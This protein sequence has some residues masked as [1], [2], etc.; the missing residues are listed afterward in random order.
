MTNQRSSAAYTLSNRHRHLGESST[1]V[2]RGG[3]L[4]PTPKHATIFKT[5]SSETFRRGINALI[6]RLLVPWSRN[7]G[8]LVRVSMRLSRT[9][10]ARPRILACCESP[11][12]AAT[13][14]ALGTALRAEAAGGCKLVRVSSRGERGFTGLDALGEVEGVVFEDY[15]G[16][17]VVSH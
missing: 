14:S 1:C 10:L 12:T 15:V 11:L 6:R 13:M 17:C 9:S 3:L 16:V 2:A 8:A 4:V 5:F 7:E